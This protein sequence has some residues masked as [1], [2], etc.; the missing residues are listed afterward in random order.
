MNKKQKELL[1]QAEKYTLGTPITAIYI[2]PS[3]RY[4]K[5]PDGPN[6]FDHMILVGEDAENNKLY[7]INENEETDAICLFHLA[8]VR[9]IDIP[10]DAGGAVRVCFTAAIV[11][12]DYFSAITPQAIK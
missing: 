4:Y 3:G 5:S 9:T 12:D 8:E 2:I 11:I 7:Y 10:H 6:G 1:A